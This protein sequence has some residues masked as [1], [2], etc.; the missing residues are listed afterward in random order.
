MRVQLNAEQVRSLRVE[1]GM[2]KRELAAAAGISP[3]TAR[4]AEN[5]VSVMGSTAWKV[6]RALEVDP[7]QSLGRAVR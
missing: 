3:T 1:Q 6:A 2:T 7:P 5:G 4:N